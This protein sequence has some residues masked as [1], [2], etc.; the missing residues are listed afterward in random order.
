MDDYGD[1]LVHAVRPRGAARAGGPRS[2]ATDELLA[3]DKQLAGARP[4]QR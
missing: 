1:A 2:R 3:L 4:T